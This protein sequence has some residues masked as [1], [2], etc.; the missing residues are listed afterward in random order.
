MPIILRYCSDLHLEFSEFTESKLWDF[1][2]DSS[3][4]YYLALL[5][6]IGYPK[7][8]RLKNFLTKVSTIY[9]KIFY[10]IGNHEYY[11]PDTSYSECKKILQ[12]LCD[13][14]NIILLDNEVHIDG[15]YKFIGTT[16]WSNIP[17]NLTFYMKNMINDYRMILDDNH[18]PIVVD[19]T[20][21]WNHDAVKF[22]EREL[23]HN[24]KCIVLTHHAPLFSNKDKEQYTADK[25]YLMG[26]NN[27]A[28][29]NDLE[30][31][32]NKPIIAWLYGHTHY[33]SKFKLNG[34]IIATNQ[35][36]Y[37]NESVKFNPEKYIELSE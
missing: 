8:T 17:D 26:P 1:P 30:Y 24:Y 22:I 25:K 14:Y 19:D 31:L 2:K 28:F 33:V 18:Y 29:H 3:N 9:D 15:E 23:D 6:D 11:Q 16:L 34:V 20:N 13:K 37:N 10:I 32:I 5:G 27:Y 7:S 36:G 4:K 12:S 21:K 35:L